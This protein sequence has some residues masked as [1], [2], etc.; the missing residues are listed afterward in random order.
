LIDLPWE[1]LYRPDAP[2]R[3]PLAGFLVLNPR[4]SVVRE[5]PIVFQRITSSRQQER[6]L[7]AGTLS[8][9]DDNRY[10]DRFEVKKEYEGISQALDPVREFLVGNFITASDDHNE[11]RETEV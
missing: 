8:R 1:F 10:E 3:Q 5:A 11:F 9:L 4:I 2:A 7:F 6:L